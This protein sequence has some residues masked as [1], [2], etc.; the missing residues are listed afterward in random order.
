M[1]TKDNRYLDK[2]FT[3]SRLRVTIIYTYLFAFARYKAG[4]TI[5][6]QSQRNDNVRLD[7]NIKTSNILPNTSSHLALYFD[8][9]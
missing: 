8:R 3:S 5:K 2:N 9:E 6:Y 4:L 7:K 1:L